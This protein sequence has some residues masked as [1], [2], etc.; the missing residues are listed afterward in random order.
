MGYAD[1]GY[2]DRKH[3]LHPQMARAAGAT[4]LLEH[5]FHLPE[6]WRQEWRDTRFKRIL[7][8]S[9]APEGV[10]DSRE[11]VNVAP[12]AKHHAQFSYLHLPAP[13]RNLE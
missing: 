8:R 3:N 11:G 6:R 5:D 2:R 4:A 13:S 12:K 1:D 9:L 7:W 10:A